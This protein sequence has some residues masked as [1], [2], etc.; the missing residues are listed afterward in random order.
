MP[1]LNTDVANNAVGSRGSLCVTAIARHSDVCPNVS[2]TIET[3][4]VLGF[5]EGH[6]RNRMSP[7]S[8]VNVGPIV[9]VQWKFA[10]Q[11]VIAMGAPAIRRAV[12]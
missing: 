6:N 9:E 7:K 2:F 5:I 12:S 3:R 8:R 1:G 11:R 10:R 4:L